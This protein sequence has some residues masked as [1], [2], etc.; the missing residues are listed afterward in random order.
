MKYFFIKLAVAL[1]C[2]C[3]NSVVCD[4]SDTSTQELQFMLNSIEHELE[5]R[6]ATLEKKQERI[7]K[8]ESRFSKIINKNSWKNAV[9]GSVLTAA[10]TAHPAGLLV[11]GIAGSMVGKSKK[12]NEAEEQLAA[13]EYEIIV[14]EDNFLTE[15][16]VRLARFAGDD[17]DP[18]MLDDEAKAREELLAVVPNEMP[19]ERSD[20][21]RI[22]DEDSDMGDVDFER[23]STSP[24]VTSQPKVM[25]MIN[26]ASGSGNPSVRSPNSMTQSVAGQKSGGRM[27]LESCYGRSSETAAQKRKRLPHCFY[28][29]Y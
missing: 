26:V 21:L 5:N 15:G 25:P 11:G 1:I 12:Y 4:V 13:I 10:V 28:M 9:I 27:E 2:F 20:I 6:G 29:M 14:D 22:S 7:K 23:T 16:E 18:S 8:A 24:T 3:S 19:D 17:V